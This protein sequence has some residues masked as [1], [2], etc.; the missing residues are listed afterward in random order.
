MTDGTGFKEESEQTTQ[1]DI[2]D[3]LRPFITQATGTAGRSLRRL[4]NLSG[5]DLVAGFS[6]EQEEAFRRATAIA[7]GGG[8]FIPTIQRELLGIGGGEGID[9]FLPESVRGRLS[10]FGDLSFLPESARSSLGPGSVPSSTAAT[11]T[12]AQSGGLPAEV[13]SAL[14]GVSGD[15]LSFLDPSS[16][17]A[18]RDLTGGADISPVATDEFG[19][20]VGG[21][22]I[23]ASSRSTLESTASGDFLFGGEGFDAAVDAAVRAARPGILSTFG[24]AGAGGA[25]GGL[26]RTAIARSAIDAFAEQFGQERGRQLSAAD[27][28][29][30]LGLADR[31]QR[32]DAAGRAADVGLANNQL[33]IDDARSRLGA[34]DTLSN[35]GLLERGQSIDAANLLGSL[36]LA[37]RDQQVDAARLL[38]DLDLAQQG[39]NASSAGL[40]ADIFGQERNRSLSSAGLLVDLANSERGR[41]LQALGLLPEASLLDVNLL[42][43][44]G[45]QRRSLEQQL[46]NAPLEVQLQLLNAA[47][48]GLP[49]SSLLGSS[50]AGSRSGFELS[51]EDPFG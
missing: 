26:A 3:F 46:L 44:I 25:T 47:L 10:G 40:L 4:E 6:P 45:G 9:E 5:G 43:Q 42:E 28:L 2:P 8:G 39:R 20:I 17:A 22:F 32:L 11:L 51:F 24:R 49:I 41:Q 37:N 19:N 15:D 38:G 36:D 30:E 27:R 13:L 21:E 35:L 29:A 34:A 12:G 50:S 33:A 48:G 7:G 18:L 16:V 14:R 23:P 1:V 31:S